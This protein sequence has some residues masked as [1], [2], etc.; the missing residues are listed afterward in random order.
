MAPI[1]A[2]A[3][4]AAPVDSDFATVLS[5]LGPRVAGRYHTSPE[6]IEDK[7]EL[8]DIVLG[9]GANGDVHLARSRVDDAKEL[10]V[11]SIS[12]S[13]VA[14]FDEWKMLERQLEV[15]LLVDC[16]QLVGATDVYET[17]EALHLVMPYMEG[18]A[19]LK[20]E[21][22]PR[23][24]EDAAKDLAREMLQALKY[25]HSQGIVH[26]DIKP[27]NCV[28]EKELGT[29]VRLID[30]DLCFFWKAGDPKM[31]Y[32]CGTPGYMSPELRRGKGYTSQTDMWSLGVTLFRLLVGEMP[33]S[34]EEIPDQDDVDAVL[35]SRVTAGLGPVAHDLL[36]SLLR[37]DPDERLNADDALLHPFF[38][39][40]RA[41]RAAVTPCSVGRRQR[42]RPRR[43]GRANHGGATP[44]RCGGRKTTQPSNKISTK[45]GL[46]KSCVASE[47]LIIAPTHHK[48]QHK[49]LPAPPTLQ[50]AAVSRWAD[51]S[52]DDE[53]MEV[54]QQK[55]TA[56]RWADL[57]DDDDD[58][59]VG[60]L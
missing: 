4:E 33:F 55:V 26:R 46:Q 2:D 37:V 6:R 17:D 19:L 58:D 59:I 18:G 10:A 22:A 42:Q 24:S 56:L 47:I 48:A 21:A 36:A 53:V 54:I 23:M 51:L 27:S 14:G 40:S 11:K 35:A 41:T 7:Y 1:H 29:R 34:L 28:L 15:A 45:P 43:C 16:P 25:L 5:R 32:A 12:F 50:K 9:T 20:D 49:A 31:R 30:F 13:S 60:L 3:S 38:A 52:D 39:V 57:E 44:A 8:T